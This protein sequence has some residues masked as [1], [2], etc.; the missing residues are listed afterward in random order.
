MTKSQWLVPYNLILCFH[1]TNKSKRC[2]VRRKSTSIVQKQKT[3]C[4]EVGI[5]HRCTIASSKSLKYDLL[6][7]AITGSL[8]RLLHS[9]ACTLVHLHMSGSERLAT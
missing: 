8:F 7:S 9:R 6:S 4:G 2:L 1:L 5:Y 3:S